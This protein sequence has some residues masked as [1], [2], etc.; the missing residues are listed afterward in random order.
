MKNRIGCIMGLGIVLAGGL[1]GIGCGV[2]HAM[3]AEKRPLLRIGVYDSRAIAIAYAHSEHFSNILKQKRAEL[4]QAKKDGDTEK[5][6]QIE[7]WGPAQQAK[8]HLQGFGTAPVHTCF[9]PVK[10]KLPDIATACQVDVMVS[11]WEFDYLASDAQV[12]DITD[13]LVALYTPNER[14]M[15]SIR[16]LKNWAPLPEK[17]ILEHAH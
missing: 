14:A 9:E 5:V 11:K 3:E 4:D 10:E 1:L 7:A 16:Q 12:K 13:E 15:K 8:A 6:R 17:E 2:L